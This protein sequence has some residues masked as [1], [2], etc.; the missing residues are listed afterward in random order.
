MNLFFRKKNKKYNADILSEQKRSDASHSDSPAGESNPFI[1]KARGTEIPKAG[2]R[3]F[4]CCHADDCDFR[5]RLIEDILSQDAGADCVVTYLN[6]SPKPDINNFHDELLESK[7][8]ILAVTESLLCGMEQGKKPEAFSFAVNNAVP[9]LP[10]SKDSGYLSRFNKIAGAVHV[11]AVTDAEYRVK[12]KTQLDNFLVSKEL[13]LDIAQNAFSANLFL[14]YRKKDLKEARMFMQQFHAIADFDTIAIWYDNYLTAGRVFDNEIRESIDKSDAFVLLVTPHLMETGN[15]VLTEEYP[16]ARNNTQKKIIAVEAVPTDK[17]SFDACYPSVHEFVGFSNMENIFRSSLPAEQYSENMTSE[18]LFLLGMAYLKAILVERNTE[19]AIRFLGMATSYLDNYSLKAS[20]HL[21][22]I[23]EFGTV[24]PVDYEK[25]LKWREKCLNLSEELFGN[26]SLETAAAYNNLGLVYEKMGNIDD[27][28]SALNSDL[29]ISLKLCGHEHPDV[30]IT[31]NN[32][33]ELLRKKGDL[34][35]AAKMGEEA[36]DIREHVLGAGDPALASSYNNLSAVYAQMGQLEKA[37][38]LAKKAIDVLEKTRGEKSTETAMVYGST[39]TV[40]DELERFDEALFYASKCSKIF[41][42]VLGQY[43]IDTAIAYKKLSLVYSSMNK[44]TLSFKYI[45]K[46]VDIAERILGKNHRDL[47]DY[48]VEMGD[49]QQLLHNY[50]A[51]EE[52]YDK[53]LG[54]LDKCEYPPKEI[55]VKVILS[56]A[57]CKQTCGNYDEA[58]ALYRKALDYAIIELGEDHPIL[59]TAYNDMGVLY[60]LKEQYN[61]ALEMYEKALVIREKIF[62]TKSE[63]VATTCNN[64]ALVSHL[65]GMPEKAIDFYQRALSIQT[66]LFAENSPD[67]AITYSNLALLYFEQKETDKALKT[68]EC[69]VNIAEKGMT[70]GWPPLAVPYNTMAIIS[71]GLGHYSDAI[72]YGLRAYDIWA[73]ELPE[74]HPDL[75]NAFAIVGKAYIALGHSMEE[76]SDWVN[77]NGLLT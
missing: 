31:Y 5:D 39:A 4:L 60:R 50:T 35:N 17:N 51:A 12:L 3:V 54:I 65:L 70:V 22:V 14:S 42:S 27:A 63:M 24:G 73:K 57:L 23:Y 48:Y 45:S 55:K 52:T 61:K 8:I 2:Q 32:L 16:Y 46:A 47:A 26:E 7:V 20:E 13:Y 34:E 38:D 19:Y 69:S 1:R 15:Y 37:L 72:R 10:I 9:L 43:H 71:E 75:M 41:E 74:G 36:L 18:R 76:F 53:A 11:I 40:L 30:A 21:A 58:L 29:T 28:V 59:A 62:G 25:A 33:G 49:I 68:A 64:I 56:K 66:S 77:T 67:I 6:N 44:F